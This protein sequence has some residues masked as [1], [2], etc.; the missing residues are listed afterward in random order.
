MRF[1]NFTPASA[2]QKWLILAGPVSHHIAV[3][4]PHK[5]AMPEASSNRAIKS[6]FKAVA[7]ASALAGAPPKRKGNSKT[8]LRIV[9]KAISFISLLVLVYF[10]LDLTIFTRTS[11][12]SLAVFWKVIVPIVPILLIIAPGLWRN[13]CPLA[14]INMA[15]YRLSV[16]L[17]VQKSS[18]PARPNHLTTTRL[19]L[20]LNRHGTKIGI[21]ILCLIIPMR[22]IALNSSPKALGLVLLIFIAIAVLAGL[23][24]PFK[25]GWCTSICPMYSVEK[26]YGMA[27]ILKLE[28]QQCPTLVPDLN[29]SLPCS[30]CSRSCLDLKLAPL[31]QLSPE[32]PNSFVQDK[33]AI[34]F[35][36]IMPGLVLAYTI[37][38]QSLLAL[39]LHLIEKMG[40]VYGV[41]ALFLIASHMFYRVLTKMP[42][43][44]MTQH[45]RHVNLCF[46]FC[47]LNCY[48]LDTLPRTINFVG[49]FLNVQSL[50]YP[51][52]VVL[53][54][55]AIATTSTHWLRRAW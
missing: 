21:T 19:Y 24:M 41:F 27:P 16:W 32:K 6:I 7:Q 38:D 13:I 23:Q 4:P 12:T 28:N 3:S 54:F 34:L 5:N 8:F 1:T 25:S 10:V 45:N 48:Y 35:I 52:F 42:T 18:L 43:K 30:G 49:H 40:F 2:R 26:A 33:T 46:V 39:N 9:I 31:G 47:A 37:L 36:S 51:T 15:T 17:K 55:A 11:Q 53:A 20:W 44:N 14:L 50:Y 22:L 29:I